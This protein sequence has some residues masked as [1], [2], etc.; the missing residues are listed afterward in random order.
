MLFPLEMAIARL[1]GYSRDHTEKHASVLTEFFGTEDW[2]QLAE[3]R[4]TDTQSSSLRRGLVE[5]YLGQLRSTGWKH[6]LP[7]KDVRYT[8]RRL[9]Y[10]LLFA[11]NHD[12]AERLARWANRHGDER[13]QLRFEF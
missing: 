2:R 5:L 12:V 10:R 11:S 13:E 4:I 1:V 8:G 6:A 9:L 7:V 3:S